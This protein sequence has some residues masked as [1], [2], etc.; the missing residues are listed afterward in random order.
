[1][2]V[3]DNTYSLRAGILNDLM[4]TWKNKAPIFEK[5]QNLL[6]KFLPHKNIRK[7]TFVWKESVPFPKPW[8]YGAGRTYQTIADRYIQ[9]SY[10]PYELSIPYN[11][12]DYEDD[13]LGDLRSHIE[14]AVDRFLMLPDKFLSE[15]LNNS[16]SLLPS[17][18][19]AYDGV[20]IY[21][22]TDGDGAARFDA[23]GGNI[24][25]GSGTGTS[26]AILYDVMAAQ[27]RFLNFKDTQGQPIFR[28]EDVALDKLHLIIPNAL[29][30]VVQKAAKA[31]FIHMD[32]A[33]VTAETNFLKGTFKYH[34]NPYLTDSSDYFIALEH[35]YWKPFIY[36]S[37]KELR[38]IFSEFS[39]SDRAREYNEEA[40]MADIRVGMG[41]WSPFVTI[42]VNN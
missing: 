10:T 26:A 11:Y 8:S 18:N 36:R 13:Q 30:E 39:N 34:L 28:E 12:H 42:K 27:R 7:A 19:N 22:A 16:A 35:S 20:A 37:P 21:S 29:N 24:I 5:Q 9:V 3:V 2:P 41:P 32:G 31:E 17:I 15:Y 1:M 25:T 40:L 4:D 14:T 38:Q 33:S 23:T 6:V